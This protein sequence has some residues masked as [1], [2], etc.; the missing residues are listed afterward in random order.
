MSK[1]WETKPNYPHYQLDVFMLLI[2][3]LIV[4]IPYCWEWRLPDYFRDMKKAFRN[5]RQDWL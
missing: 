1:P 3:G 4:W 2:I 5:A